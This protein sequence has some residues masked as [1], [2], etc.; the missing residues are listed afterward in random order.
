[1]NARP[2]HLVATPRFHQSHQEDDDAIRDE[3]LHGLQQEAAYLAPKFLYDRLGSRLFC[4]ITDLHEY[5]PTRTEARILSRYA[6]DI[7]R[8]I[9]PVGALIDLGAGDCAKAGRLFDTV[10]PAQYVPVDISVDYLRDTVAGLQRAHPRLEIVALGQDF[11]SD[12]TLPPDVLPHNRLFFYPGSSIGNFSPEQALTLLTRIA[13]HCGHDGGL[14]IG[15][16]RPKARPLLETAYDD[17][18]GVTAAF[19]LNGLLHANRLAGTDFN[20]RE[21]QHVA[22][23][24]MPES[25]VEMHL[26]ARTDT[27]V[28]WPM[29]QRRFAAGE[30][31]HTENAYKYEPGRFTDLLTRAGFDDVHHWTDPEGWFSLFHARRSTDTSRVPTP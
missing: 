20:V 24:D 27:L 9:G 1:M 5:Y 23:F 18:L 7:A 12:L 19:N 11:S 4:A 13:D 26:R 22:H 3:L 6:P 28:R 17:A 29:G 30:S 31:I 2:D 21:W 10:H 25:R 15:V 16:D 8:R 14:L